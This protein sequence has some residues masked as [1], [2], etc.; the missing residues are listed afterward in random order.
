MQVYEWLKQFLQRFSLTN[1]LICL[2]GGIEDIT[3]RSLRLP[4]VCTLLLALHILKSTASVGGYMDQGL[5]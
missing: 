4:T 3:E 1:L 5:D 2:R